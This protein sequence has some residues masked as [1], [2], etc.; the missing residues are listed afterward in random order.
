MSITLSLEPLDTSLPGYQAPLDESL[1]QPWEDG[2]APDADGDGDPPSPP[3]L[4]P[5][6]SRSTS[7]QPSRSTSSQPSTNSQ[8]SGG[9]P[10]Q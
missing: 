2:S 3:N 1:V 9:L 4:S 7:S 10:P 6:T 5:S 8:P